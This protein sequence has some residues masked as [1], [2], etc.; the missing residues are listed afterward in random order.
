[1]YFFAFASGE[2]LSETINFNSH[3]ILQNQRNTFTTNTL[4]LLQRY[5]HGSGH[6]LFYSMMQ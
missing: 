6:R 5:T 1:M 4:K 3:M 2:I